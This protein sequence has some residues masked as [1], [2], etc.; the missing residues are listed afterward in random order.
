MEI[1]T[2]TIS[3][4]GNPCAP[5]TSL[6]GVIQVNPSPSIDSDFILNNDVTH[7]TCNGGSDG[8]IVIPAAS[9]AFDLR[10]FGGQ[11][12]V[13][14]VDRLSIT[15]NFNMGDRVHVIIN[16]NQ[17]T[18]I[19]EETAFGS[20]VAENNLSIASKL[21]DIIN[22]AI[23]ALAVPV[24]ASAVAPAD[25]VLNADTAGV[26][27]TVTFPVPAT[28]TLLNGDISN[29]SVVTNLPLNYN[30]LWT[31]PDGSTNTNLSIY[32][33]QAGDYTFEVT[34][35]GCSSGVASFTIE[36]PD[37]LTI[38]T[39]SCNGAF[40]ALVEGGTA[41]YTLTLFDSNDIEIELQP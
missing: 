3:T 28:Q 15:G 1:F 5:A 27:F 20:G 19:V 4:T 37:T 33:L 10:I 32:N 23:P 18:H 12:S 24:T 16:G 21:T 34:L 7:V 39:T 41:P 25:V 40:T 31:Y 30:Y 26:T 6:S 13:R 9:P 22:N 17:Y 11:N 29:A 2:Y 35:N 14:Q 38:S 36:E 8:S